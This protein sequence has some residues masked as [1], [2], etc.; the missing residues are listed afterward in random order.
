LEEAKG[1]YW[2]SIKY[3]LFP[4]LGLATIAGYI[5]QEHRITL[6]DEHVDPITFNDDPD[7]ILIQVYITNAYRAYQ[8]ADHYL[9][10]RKIVI[11][12]GLHVTSLP[13]EA[14][15]HATAIVLGPGDHVFYE[16]INDILS[17]NIKRRYFSN[18]RELINI[19]PIRR[20][21][22][23]EKK[24]LVKNSLVV[25]RGCPF[26][27]DFCYKESFFDKGKS[28][29][30]YSL[31]RALKEIDSLSGKHLFFLDDNI[32]TE[33]QFTEDLFIELKS[34]NRIIQGAGTIQG[35]NNE[36]II[37]FAANAG[38]KSIFVGFESINKENMIRLNKPH[39]YKNSYDR[40]ITILNNYN[41]KI[42]ASFVFG[43]D[44]D[45]KDVFKRTT[46]WAVEHGITTATF[47]ILTPYPGTKLYKKLEK[48]QRIISKNWN[49]Y[50]TRNVV[51]KPMKMEI[52]D[53]EN[54]YWWSYKNFYKTG[55]IIKSAM[56][57]KKTVMKISNFMYSFGWKKIEPLW[58]LLIWLKKLSYS[59]PLLE[60]VLKS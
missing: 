49:L 9:K 33:N 38:L 27:C 25:T 59:V 18:K 35:I 28:Y 39:N 47:H 36:K 14:A 1:K 26:S 13:E 54:G 7:V 52:N 6:T 21:L 42:N 40:A 17:R 34:R 44:E 4:P 60:K 43:M 48:E 2:R 53:L 8:I 12:G 31:D 58:D 51:F 11:L 15:Q 19:P 24:Y 30:T 45:D 46:E 5:P 55:A 56:A 29:Y 10:N 22:I 50:N 16:V 3:S 32:L 37:G 20:D 57:H 41:I 23:N